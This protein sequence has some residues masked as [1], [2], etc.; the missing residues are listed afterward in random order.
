VSSFY[1]IQLLFIV[2]NE[3]LFGKLKKMRRRR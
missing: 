1:Q 2:G 3:V